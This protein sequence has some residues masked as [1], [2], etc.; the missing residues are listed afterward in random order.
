MVTTRWDTVTG[1]VVARMDV[2]TVQE[3]VKLLV[4]VPVGN[5][6][7]WKLREALGN[8]LLHSIQG[9]KPDA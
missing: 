5:G 4:R 1:E 6:P 3:L 8:T 2:S 9:G 7:L